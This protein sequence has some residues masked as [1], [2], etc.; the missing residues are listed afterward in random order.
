MVECLLFI[1]VLPISQDWRD[2]GL[3]NGGWTR[4]AVAELVGT[5]YLV[6][7]GA[8]AAALDHYAHGDV[9]LIGF[10]LANGLALGTG[11]TATMNISGG[12]LNPA[13]TVAM[14]SLGKIRAGLAVV[15]VVAQ[16]LGAILAGL[17]VYAS[18]PAADVRA[19]HAGAPA[20]G[21]GIGPGHGVVLEAVLTFL[22]VTSVLLT[23]VD[24]RAPK[25]GGYGIGLTVLFDVLAGGAAT[26]AAMN[27]ARSFG[28]ALVS[29]FWANEWVY[30]VG[31]VLGAL[32]AAAVY[33]LF[34]RQ[35]E[36]AA[37]ASAS[38]GQAGKGKRK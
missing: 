9:G 37:A 28:P 21:A 22:L 20:L 19:V 27:P 26:G 12:H 31:P 13:V 24:W 11:V 25:V 6:F 18:F 36:P 10:A 29:G 34:L 38:A 3:T 1:P 23:A 16:L 15:Y 32:V 5:F 4:P 33:A 14:W 30:W 2:V 7:I 35:P 17:L 8:A